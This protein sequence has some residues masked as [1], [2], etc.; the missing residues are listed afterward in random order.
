M[1]NVVLYVGHPYKPF[2]TKKENREYLFTAPS[3]FAANSR[4]LL[5]SK[6]TLSKTNINIYKTLNVIVA[7]PQNCTLVIKLC[8]LI[9]LS[10]T[11]TT[12]THLLLVIKERSAFANATPICLCTTLLVFSIY[13]WNL[14]CGSQG[15]GWRCIKLVYF[16]EWDFQSMEALLRSR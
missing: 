8:V 10:V 1:K 2:W 5:T 3:L 14:S 4:S 9:S 13:T 12:L 15:V 11:H 6:S 16:A 7:L